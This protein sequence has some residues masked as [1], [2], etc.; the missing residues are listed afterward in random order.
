M[1]FS[2]CA[3]LPLDVYD[4]YAIID[5]QILKIIHGIIVHL[6]DLDNIR[7]PYIWTLK[8]KRGEMIQE[9]F[10]ESFKGKTLQYLNEVL[11]QM[12]K[13]SLKDKYLGITTPT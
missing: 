2:D 10:T 5:T 8:K 9:C 6:V 3:Q 4:I 7:N 1:T 12:V 11:F 13:L